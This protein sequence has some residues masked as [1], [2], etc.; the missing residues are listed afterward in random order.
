MGQIKF[1]L[2]SGDPE[3]YKTVAKLAKRNGSLL[4]GGTTNPTLIAKKLKGKKISL[5]K[6]FELQK[7]TVLEI[8]DIVPGAVSAE[9]YADKRTTEEEMIKQGEEIAGWHKRVAVKLPTTIEGFKARTALRKQGICI[10]NTLV[11]S[12]EQIFAVFLHEQII[13]QIYDPKEKSWHPFISP[14][15]GRLDD[16]GQDGMMLVED[17]MEIKQ[18]FDFPVWMLAASIRR[19]EHVYRAML[20]GCDLIT[21]P[22]D[23][24]C[25][26]FSLLLKEK[27][28]I[29]P[30]RY[31]KSLKTIAYWK[32]PKQLLSIETPK[33]F[34]TALESGKLN[35]SHPLTDKGVSRFAKDW[36]SILK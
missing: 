10:N 20:A 35:I 24:Y 3:E 9:V 27:D 6:A 5:K 25:E 13:Q 1:L 22:S 8:L 4:W 23:I 17:G 19:V 33:E 29:D 32:P 36:R 28:A 7:K 14:F 30:A 18:K 31:A 12:Q 26:W 16:I 21:A 34:V 2:D 11:F 15:V